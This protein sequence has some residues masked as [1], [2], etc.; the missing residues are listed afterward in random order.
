MALNWGE[1]VCCA[2]ALVGVFPAVGGDDFDEF[3]SSD[4][5][6]DLAGAGYAAERLLGESARG[7]IVG[8]RAVGE[9]GVADFVQVFYEAERGAEVWHSLLMALFGCGESLF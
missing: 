6:G 9:D 1:K 8:E 7:V 4:V 3:E 2:S 5:S